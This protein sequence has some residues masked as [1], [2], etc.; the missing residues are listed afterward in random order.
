M[1]DVP[2]AKAKGYKFFWAPSRVVVWPGNYIYHLAGVLPAK[3][4]MGAV[5]L[6]SGEQMKLMETPIVQT[7]LTH[8]QGDPGGA[9]LD[10]T[11]GVLWYE[12]KDLTPSEDISQT[13]VTQ[14]GYGLPHESWDSTACH[15]PPF[16]MMRRPITVGTSPQ[17]G[18][19]RPH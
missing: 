2:N 16:I 19:Q 11:I 7:V 9:E 1:I 13:E 8:D 12:F 18:R 4:C 17:R 5:H 15:S 10:K 14:V 3:F 6:D